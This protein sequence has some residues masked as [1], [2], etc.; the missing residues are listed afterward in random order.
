MLGPRRV[1]LACAVGLLGGCS[2]APIQVA[3]I[4]P[5]ALSDGLLAHWPL[6]EGTGTV[7]GDTSN[8]GHSG[9]L[10]GPGV[11][12]VTG[13]FGSALHFSG[14]D[15][16]SVSPFPHATP[17]YT[18]S[19]WVSIASNEIG[20]PI[21]NL[22]S[23]EILGG[24]WALFEGQNVVGSPYYEFEFA[25]PSA[26][27]MPYGGLTFVQ[28]TCVT[29]DKWVHLAA[30]L[31]GDHETLTLYAGANVVTVPSTVAM[32]PGS[33]MLEIGHSTRQELGAAFPVTGMIDDVAI[34]NRALEPEEVAQLAKA[35][36]PDPN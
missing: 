1:T 19:A 11:T 25:V 20:A 29:T 30:V 32:L 33:T 14:T 15:M 3:A 27:A 35:E 34:Y 26:P 21:A 31:D 6:N 13:K 5:T 17:N 23:T 9:V 2:A 36:V 16:V 10:Q 8:N 22:V 24:G 7:A 4:D 18:V 28:C 12:W